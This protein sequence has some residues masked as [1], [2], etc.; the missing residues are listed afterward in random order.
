MNSFLFAVNA[1]FAMTVGCSPG[2]APVSQ[3]P[4]DPSNPAAAEGVSAPQPTLLASTSLPA[5]PA[6]DP[7]AGHQHGAAPAASAGSAAAE[8]GA[9]TVVYTCP[10]HPQIT[11][12]TPGRCPI[13]GMNL[14]LKK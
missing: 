1:A 8:A 9:P 2:P 14:V 3:S 13:C 4:K 5:T 7:H 12:P 11:S 10:M 6:A